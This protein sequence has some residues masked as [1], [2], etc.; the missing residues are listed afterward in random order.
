MGHYCKKLDKLECSKQ[1]TYGT[2]TSMLDHKAVI[3]AKK[4]LENEQGKKNSIR[5]AVILTDFFKHVRKLEFNP[6]TWYK[7]CNHL[8]Q[9]FG[10]VFERLLKQSMNIGIRLVYPPGL[11]HN[12]VKVKPLDPFWKELTPARID[13]R[14]NITDKEDPGYIEEEHR[15]IMKCFREWGTIATP[16]ATIDILYADS[17]G[18]YVNPAPTAKIR[19]YVIPPRGQRSIHNRLPTRY[20]EGNFSKGD[21]SSISN[22]LESQVWRHLF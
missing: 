20:K 13:E 3:K 1:K 15:H 17:E 2:I 16:Q 18:N 5:T 6:D 9:Y 12:G 10:L 4:R 8:S 14:L 11:H 7:L 19:G 21:K 22:L